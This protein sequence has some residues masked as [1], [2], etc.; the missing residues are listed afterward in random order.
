MDDTVRNED[1]LLQNTGRI[2]KKRIRGEGDGQVVPLV[3]LKSGAVEEIRAVADEIVA[4]YHVVPKNFCE[5][6]DG[7]V[8]EGGANILEGVVVGRED[9]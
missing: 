8:G 1:I 6:F 4:L 9:S 2:D 7:H 3:G 5:L